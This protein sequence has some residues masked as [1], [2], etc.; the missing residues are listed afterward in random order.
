MN[1]FIINENLNPNQLINGKSEE[2]S[3]KSEE[4][5]GNNIYDMTDESLSISESNLFQL[6]ETLKQREAL[7]K[8]LSERLQT[9]LQSRDDITKTAECMVAQI[10][11][12]KQQLK[13]VSTSLLNKTTEEQPIFQDF[14]CQTEWT[15]EY[16]IED[17]RRQSVSQLSQLST[18]IGV[19]IGVN[20]FMSSFEEKTIQIDNSVQ[21]ETDLLDI[22]C[23]QELERLKQSLC[24]QFKEREKQIESKLSEEVNRLET[25]LKSDK[26]QY[27]DQNGKLEEE[28]QR[29]KSY[30]CDLEKQK[31]SLK[32]IE[33]D[34]EVPNSK[35]S[36]SLSPLLP[37]SSLNLSERD[38]HSSSRS[39]IFQTL[40]K[41]VF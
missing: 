24:L 13:F 35:L 23:K 37:N 2:F 27:I 17:V 7:I 40:Q 22:K 33:F 25:Q 10:E 5:N 12:L 15:E 39:P 31:N 16:S 19:P 11:E 18:P 28:I 4:I 14:E 26:R 3:L 20:T 6:N 21:T 38:R 1:K 36:R 8:Q 30:I 29:L 32:T 41:Y 34:E 9:T